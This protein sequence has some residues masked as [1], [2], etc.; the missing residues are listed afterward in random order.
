MKKL[1]FFLSVLLLLAF[2][3]MLSSSC[4]DKT[5]IPRNKDVVSEQKIGQTRE[6]QKGTEEPLII[7]ENTIVFLVISQKDYDA[8]VLKDPSSEEHL[9]DIL[10]DFYTYSTEVSKILEKMNFTL[11]YECRKQIWFQFPDGRTEKMAFN[12]EDIYGM[13]LFAKGK[14]PKLVTKFG[15]FFAPM[16][17][18]ISEYFGLKIE[19]K[20]AHFER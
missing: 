7:K 10:S 15:A 18:I 14:A 2:A 12:P 19:R 1:Y 13:A 8:I 16:A 3:P 6:V 5:A 20:D 17:E 11:K 4:K 9:P